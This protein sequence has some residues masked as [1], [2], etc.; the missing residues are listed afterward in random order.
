MRES[1][2]RTNG[3]N[4]QLQTSVYVAYGDDMVLTA[5]SRT[6]LEKVSGLLEEKAMNYRLKTNKGKTKCMRMGADIINISSTSNCKMKSYSFEEV[7]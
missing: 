2:I 4:T 7:Q 3:F 6:E 1:G 5:R